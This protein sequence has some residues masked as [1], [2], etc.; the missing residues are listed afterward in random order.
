ME[1]YLLIYSFLNVYKCEPDFHVYDLFTRLLEMCRLW[2][3]AN[4][5]YQ[6]KVRW[7][8]IPEETAMGR[9]SHNLKR[10]LYL[11]NDYADIEVINCF[12]LMVAIISSV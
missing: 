7:Y 4:G 8:I 11:T 10:E 9:Q 1:F 6:C 5:I 12:L 2:K 3:E